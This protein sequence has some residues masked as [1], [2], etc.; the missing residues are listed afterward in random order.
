MKSPY[1]QAV[2]TVHGVS[3]ESIIVSCRLT[4]NMAQGIHLEGGKGGEGGRQR[5]TGWSTQSLAARPAATVNMLSE[6]TDTD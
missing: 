3:P 1:V 5:W 6:A 4:D 2:W